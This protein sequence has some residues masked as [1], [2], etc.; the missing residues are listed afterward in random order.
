[1][2]QKKCGEK[3][4]IPVYTA[5]AIISCV[6]YFIVL[7]TMHTC[8]LFKKP[9]FMLVV[10]LSISDCGFVT[11][12]AVVYAIVTLLPTGEACK[13]ITIV[14]V[15]V[16]HVLFYLSC[17]L[18]VGLTM[19]QFIAV[20]YGLRYQSIVTG[21]KIKILIGICVLVLAI[22]NGLVLIDKT[23]IVILHTRM[24]RSRCLLNS[25][26]L[27]GSSSIMMINLMY[28]NNV[29]QKQMKRLTP[30][31][32][33]SPYWKHRRRIR[34]EVTIIT[35]VVIAVLLPQA[36][37]YTKV[38]IRHD[39]F[40]AIWLAATRGMLQLFCAL[41]PYLYL[42][43]LKP[44]KKRISQKIKNCSCASS[45]DRGI[46]QFRSKSIITLTTEI[47]EPTNFHKRNYTKDIPI[48]KKRDSSL[49]AYRYA[50]REIDELKSTDIVR[51]HMSLGF[52]MKEE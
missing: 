16:G 33:V 45:D 21:K 35:S 52:Y 49:P 10:Y 22:I 46:T 37:F 8:R 13:V 23:Y 14:A 24:I 18:S 3:T 17:C 44:L 38:Q 47:D 9:H 50:Q 4:L 15:Y 29:S 51:N 2:D 11:M 27:V 7:K 31:E 39:P 20:R 26:V 32:I 36:I 40:D 5:T 28:C 30:M 12:S 41:N 42:F 43:T 19:N 6:G 48:T 1:M 25:L 34:T